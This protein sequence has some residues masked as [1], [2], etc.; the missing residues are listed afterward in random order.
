MKIAR[1]RHANQVH[2]GL[3][4]DQQLRVVDGDIFGEF[5]PTENLIPIS[6]VS[7]LTPVS[8]S[9]IVCVGQN[10]REHIQELGLPVPKEPV[11]F[12]KPPSCLIGNLEKIIF[13]AHATRVDYEGELAIVIKDKMTRISEDQALKYVLGYSCFN[14]VTERALVSKDPFLLTVSKSFDT[15]G[16]FGPF[17]VT[18]VDPDNLELKTYLNGRIMQQ[19]NT[20]NCVFNAKMLLSFISRHITLLPGDVVITGT[21]KGIAPMKIG[22]VVEVEIDGIGKLSN[23]LAAAEA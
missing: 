21:P 23:P 4:E 18:D 20:K 7:L 22:D 13:P 10:Y 19:D 14:D 17:M 6:E 9:K 11:I 1:Y 3:V 12:L 2:F 8:P 5:K 16:P 15:F